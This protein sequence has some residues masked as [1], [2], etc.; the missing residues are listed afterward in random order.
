MIRRSFILISVFVLTA[1]VGEDIQPS[2]LIAEPPPQRDPAAPD[3]ITTPP[4]T[5]EAPLP[6]LT[7]TEPT[8]PDVPSPSSTDLL[9]QNP[10]FVQTKLGEPK[11]VRRDGHV[12]IM[13]Y[14]SGACV[15]DIVF[16]EPTSGEHFSA[17]YISARTNT[18]AI[19]E[20]EPCIDAVFQAERLQIGD[21]P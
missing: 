16:F 13:Q 20:P 5:E 4:L 9:G 8:L 19:M 18:G 21:A 15:V 3:V 2:V 10:A 14:T 11:L 1:C 17:N 6:V 7:E 12:Q